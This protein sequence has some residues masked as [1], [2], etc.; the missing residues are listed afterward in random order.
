LKGSWPPNLI[1]LDDLPACLIKCFTAEREPPRSSETFTVKPHWTARIIAA[2]TETG[3][4]R[5]R[6]AERFGVSRTT[7]W[8][9]MKELGL[10]D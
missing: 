2:L 10:D 5:D 9:K 8:R 1:G 7:L 4:K 3:G 6:A